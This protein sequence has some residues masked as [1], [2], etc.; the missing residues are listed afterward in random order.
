MSIL[1]QVR[2]EY[3]KLSKTQKQIAD[4]MFLHV[5]DF[6]KLTA[7]E[8]GDRSSTSSASVVRF[9]KY[10]NFEGLE[11]LKRQLVIDSN[12]GI[13]PI[14]PIIMQN[15]STE[16][17]AEKLGVVIENG[18]KDFFYQLDVEALDKAIDIIQNSNRI[19][20]FGVGASSLPAYDLYHKLN[21]VNKSAIFNFD[22]H[23]T[24]EFINY[25]KKG[26]VI[27][28][29]SY[30]GR[31]LEVIYPAEVAIKN[32]ASVISVTRDDKSRLAQ[33][34]SVVLKIPD[35]ENLVRI[36]AITSKI[37]AMLMAD[38]LYFGYINPRLSEIEEGIVS[39]SK[40]TSL[41][42]SKE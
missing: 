4:F 26:D 1:F 42:K 5:D 23:M 11:E 14:D 39:T 19:F 21:R 32:G 25:A 36:G 30:S 7:Q 13:V 10:F 37:N 16:Q 38:L 33:S 31:T 17:L 6:V 22:S 15:D 8:I 29:F 9:A 2:S 40:L 20:I 35:S 28:A 3:Q 41:L 34:S 27:I 24:L 18:T 12:V